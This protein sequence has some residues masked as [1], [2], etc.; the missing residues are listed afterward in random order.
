MP[1]FFLFCLFCLFLLFLY[2][3]PFPSFFPLLLLP[4]TRPSPL[5]SS[6]F[7]FFALSPSYSF[8]IHIHTLVSLLPLSSHST[9]SHLS[10]RHF[11]T[12]S[13]SL[14][15]IHSFTH[16]QNTPFV[17]NTDRTMRFFSKHSSA[18]IAAS[19]LAPNGLSLSVATTKNRQP[20]RYGPGTVLHGQVNLTLSKPILRPCLLRVVFSCIST[21]DSTTAEAEDLSSTPLA[22]STTLFEVEHLLIDNQTLPACGRHAPLHFCIKLPLCNYPPSMEEGDRSVKYTLQTILS[23]DADLANGSIVKTSTSSTP[24][25]ILYVP[26]VSYAAAMVGSGGVGGGHQTRPVV[27]NAAA[28]ATA[29]YRPSA[30]SAPLHETHGHLTVD[31]RSSAEGFKT[32]N[33]SIQSKTSVCIGD[34]ASMVLKVENNSDITLQAIRLALVRQ[35]SFPSHSGSPKVAD[36]LASSSHSVYTSFPNPISTTVH[37]ATIPV[38]KVS[39]RNSTWTQQL[40]FRIPSHLNLLPSINQSITPLLNVEYFIVPSL[41]I[42]Q[43]QGGFVSRLAASTRKRPSLDLSIFHSHASSSSGSR[44]NESTHHL[45]STSPPSSFDMQASSSKSPTDLQIAPIPITLTSVPAFSDGRKCSRPIPHHLEVEDRPTFVRDRFEEE[46]IKQLSSL[47]SLV[48]DDGDDDDLDIDLLVEEACRRRSR[49]RRDGSSSEDSDDAVEE[50]DVDEEDE[51][52]DPRFMSRVP[53]R[54]RQ[55]YRLSS[56]PITAMGNSSGLGTPPPSPPYH[57]VKAMSD[58]SMMMVQTMRERSVTRNR[59]TSNPITNAAAA[60]PSIAA[61][62]IALGGRGGRRSTLGPQSCGG[63]SKDLLM[64]LHQSKEQQPRSPI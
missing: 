52:D 2:F 20:R 8:F 3:L 44:A 41:P 33:A 60:L 37:T 53:P 30:G 49:H 24:V 7:S 54:F 32:I 42:P 62:S 36:N 27:A 47:E 51:E 15:L 46:M 11:H 22:P 23:F 16:T 58:E 13:L 14:F 40:Q 38:A 4:F 28:V 50:E 5:L 25:N 26:H 19:Y 55:P 35:I 57:L 39:N 18:N 1:L 61:A 64:D 59:A 56:L 6:L 31:S 43:R 17:I 48:M 10:L 34:H 45:L 63:L 21:L 9:H 12:H 29:S